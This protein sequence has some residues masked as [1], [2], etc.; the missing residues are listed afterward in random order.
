MSSR[1]PYEKAQTYSLSN[2]Q[3]DILYRVTAWFNATV[4]KVQNQRMSIGADYEPTLRQ[5]MGERWEPAVDHEHELLVDR[6]VFK[7]KDRGEDTYVAGRRCQWSPTEKCMKIIEH[8]FAHS[9]GIYPKWVL[10][11]HPRH[12]YSVMEASCWSTEKGPWRQQTCSL[13]WSVVLV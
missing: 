9:D 6:G 2:H 7:S 1:S 5:I 3:V 8:I 4:F 11:E 10:D 12:R 13:S